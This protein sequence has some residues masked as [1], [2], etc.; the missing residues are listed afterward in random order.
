MQGP[1]LPTLVSLSGII[2]KKHVGPEAVYPFNFAYTE[3]NG[4]VLQVGRNIT[5]I[6]L[7]VRK[8]LQTQDSRYSVPP[9]PLHCPWPCTAYMGI[10]CVGEKI[11]DTH[12]GVVRKKGKWRH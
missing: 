1:L 2:G 8:F 3:E 4:S 12:I 7:L 11:M 5:R 9:P 6:K 10:L